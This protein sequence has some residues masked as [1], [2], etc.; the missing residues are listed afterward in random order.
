[1][2]EEKRWLVLFGAIL[3]KMKADWD[4]IEEFM[5]QAVAMKYPETLTPL[6]AYNELL[7]FW[8][9]MTVVVNS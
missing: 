8:E 1:M 2:Y 9:D 4:I 7:D 6:E 5:R 3:L